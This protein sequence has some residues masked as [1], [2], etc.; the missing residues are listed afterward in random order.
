M[1]DKLNMILNGL[2]NAIMSTV[3]KPLSRLRS[4]GVEVGEEG[5]MGDWGWAVISKAMEVGILS[6]GDADIDA[7]Y[8]VFRRCA[9]L[10]EMTREALSRPGEVD[11]NFVNNLLDDFRENVEAL[12]RIKERLD[13]LLA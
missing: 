7:M 8:Y 13:L 9:T 11:E 1:I 3:E 4:M 12:S 10:E 6:L 5:T 2:R